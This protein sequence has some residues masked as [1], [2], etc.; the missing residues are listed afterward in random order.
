MI[1]N[2]KHTTVLI[3][4]LGLF[5][6]QTSAQCR[7]FT[8][9]NCLPILDGYV[10][11]DN[12]NSAQLYP[13]EA[14]ELELRFS[15]GVDH[16]VAICSHPVLGDVV[17]KVTTENNEQLWTNEGGDNFFDL[18][19]ENAVRLKFVVSVPDQPEASLTPIGCVSIL[20]G[21]KE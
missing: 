21:T 6:V 8:K 17:C 15:G 1:S 9:R 14:A 10:Q 3:A 5:A 4:L 20:V 18:L 13:G 11:S 12:Y 2:M 19:S 7:S 16:R